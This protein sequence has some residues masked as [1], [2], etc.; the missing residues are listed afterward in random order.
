MNTLSFLI[1]ASL[2]RNTTSF[3]ALPTAIARAATT[4]R[5][6]A[7]AAAAMDFA[8]LPPPRS[9]EALAAAASRRH[10]P[11]LLRFA[12]TTVG[13]I[14]RHFARDENGATLLVKRRVKDHRMRL[15]GSLRPK[16]RAESERGKAPAIAFDSNHVIIFAA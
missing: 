5:P 2:L 3:L 6:S 9:S 11:S 7:L 15:R 13:N 1:S 12:E 4:G 8:A 10:M 14:A 16:R